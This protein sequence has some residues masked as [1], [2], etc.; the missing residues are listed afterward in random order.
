MSANTNQ[1]S[2]SKR[3]H[4][5]M[6]ILVCVLLL[7]CADDPSNIV[8]PEPEEPG[9]TPPDLKDVFWGPK[10]PTALGEYHLGVKFNGEDRLVIVYIPATYQSGTA[11]P[12][13]LA[14]H[15]AHHSASTMAASHPNL[16][17]AASEKGVVLA[18]PRG[19]DD[20]NGGGYVWATF[21]DA[22]APADV[23]YLE[24]VILWLQHYLPIDAKRT[25]M[26]GLSNGAAMTQRFAAD[27]PNRIKAGV[28]FCSST[29][30]TGTDGIHV[31]FPTPQAPISMFLV[32]GGQ[33]EAVPPDGIT[34]GNEGKI[35]DSVADQLDFWVT[36][37]G[38]TMDQVVK[39]ELNDENATHYTYA[40]GSILVEM[41][42]SK[43]LGHQW[44]TQYD[45]PV[46]DWF[47]A[48]P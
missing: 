19:R 23:A 17:E 9:F 4:G 36:A 29:G 13:V 26:S 11:A 34:P 18:F 44:P 14:L 28:A 16:I 42:Y 35:Y 5:W 38:G 31:E 8:S 24:G 41:T 10:V 30:Y 37:A 27:R 39:Q 33:D 15:P 46:L 40:S 45:R 22:G 3:F 20:P 48:L 6:A 12:L 43:S 21:G 7:G 2:I 47:L 25:F 32:R 1:L